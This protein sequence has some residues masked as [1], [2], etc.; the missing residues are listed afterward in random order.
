M[1]ARYVLGA[2]SSACKTPMSIF[3][4]RPPSEEGSYHQTP[5]L[6]ICVARTCLL[7][8]HSLH[9]FGQG[10]ACICRDLQEEQPGNVRSPFLY[11]LALGKR[12]KKLSPATDWGK[13]GA[14]MQK[15]LAE[16]FDCWTLSQHHTT[17][18]AKRATASNRPSPSLARIRL[19]VG[20]NTYYRSIALPRWSRTGGIGKKPRK[21]S[22]F[23]GSTLPSEMARDRRCGVYWQPDQMCL[24]TVS[25]GLELA[26]TWNSEEFG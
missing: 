25:E 10:T 8:T 2:P 20:A 1:T 17:N 19:A 9:A 16:A 4:V 11:R 21:S 23:L 5:T 18:P 12:G 7:L 3:R 6:S 24:I 26:Q 14:V 15:I 13:E 22:T